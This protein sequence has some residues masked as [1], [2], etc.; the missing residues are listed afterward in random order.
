MKVT[1]K[2]LDPATLGRKSTERGNIHAR[3]I[4]EWLEQSL[5]AWPQVWAVCRRRTHRW[6]TP[7]RWSIRDWREELDA[8]CI[9]SAYRAILNFD[10]ERGPSL[11]SFVYYNV[12][13]GALV[14]YRREWT[15]FFR[16][17][18]PCSLPDQPERTDAVD[19]R[20]AA[21]EENQA[22]LRLIEG[23]PVKDRHLIECLFLEGQTEKDVAGGLGITQQAVSK[24][25]HK[26]LN[27]LRNTLTEP[28]QE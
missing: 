18:T 5:P 10:P 26:V 14:R 25:K 13:Q 6:R 11:D 20:F 17:G 8:E 1:A 19:E 28:G 22:V 3:L 16:H 2:R 9:A 27:G 21:E 12:L 24:R 15:F 4:T 7:P 23:L